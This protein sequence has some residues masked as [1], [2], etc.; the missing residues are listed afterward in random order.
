[1]KSFLV[2]IA[3]CCLF[4]SVSSFATSSVLTNPLA[5]TVMGKFFIP[6]NDEPFYGELNLRPERANVF[7]FES[8]AKLKFTYHLQAKKQAPLMF[9]VPGTG[10]L[11]NSLAALALAEK[12]YA[13]GYHT[14]TVDNAFSWSFALAGSKSGLP[15]YVPQ[16]AGDLYLALMQIKQKLVLEKNIHPSSYSLMG[17]SLGALQSIFMQRI[18]DDT[19]AFRFQ[20]VLLIDP[21]LDLQYAVDQIDQLFKDGSRLSGGRKILV[22][23][24]G[25][26]AISQYLKTDTSFIDINFLQTI[27]DSLRFTSWDLSYLIGG[28]FRDSL[29]DL[30]FASQ[31]VHD[32][33]ILKKHVTRSH[34]SLRYEE[35]RSFSFNDY[36]NRFVYPSIKI[37]K[38]KNYTLENMNREASLYQFSGFIKSHQNTFLIHSE[39]DFILKA[40]D[41]AWLKENFQDRALIFPYGGHCGSMNFP[42]FS[43]HLVD[44]FK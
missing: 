13:L 43:K 22:F 3:T 37:K 42:E 30:I 9:I 24:Q 38:D 41:L 35:A 28:S 19:K 4:S 15:G 39:D 33:N 7:L 17:Y 21:P 6:N 8:N 10:A 5:M 18:D 2:S 34:R 36:M 14:V 25:L 44:L 1:M 31:Q 16:D 12:L 23:N 20:K 11:H 40:E 26:Q 29:R 27:F 32:L